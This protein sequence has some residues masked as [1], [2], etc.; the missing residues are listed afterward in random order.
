M[1]SQG[2]FFWMVAVVGALVGSSVS[3]AD[4]DTE[5]QQVIRV[6]ALPERPLAPLSHLGTLGEGPGAECSGLVASR[7]HTEL[8]WSINDSG[9]E[10]RVYPIRI[11]S[12]G[13]VDSASLTSQGVLIEGARNVDWEDIAVDSQGRLVICDVGNNQNARRDLMLYVVEEPDPT[14]ESAAATTQYR[15]RYPDQTEFPAPSDQMNFD[16]EAVFTVGDTIYLLT[17]NRSDLLSSLYRLDEAD[18]DAD[19]VL[20]Y[21][22]TFDSGGGV[23]AADASA[24]GLRLVVITYTSI[25]LFERD[26]QET[27]LFASRVS[28]APYFALQT[29]SVCFADDDTLL[30]VD[31]KLGMLYSLPISE[32]TPLE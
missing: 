11:N 25:W 9:N 18:P 31:E 22:A 7:Q 6:A 28:W 21:V 15:V 17:K 23:T 13:E 16:C 4:D 32:L 19:N 12:D 29:E 20:S 30:L 26:D 27:P 3:N 2:R 10:P 8:Y 5:P 1:I 14:A 24:D